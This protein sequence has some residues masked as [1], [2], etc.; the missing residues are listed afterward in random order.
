[1]PTTATHT[2]DPQTIHLRDATAADDAT[3]KRLIRQAHLDPTSLKW[4]HFMVAE[5]DGRIVGFGQVKSYPGCNEIGSLLTLPR[6]RGLG[7]ASRLMDALEARAGMPLYLLCLQKMVPFYEQHSYETIGW[8]Q[9][10]TF[11]KLKLLPA[12]L[13][14]LVGMRVHVMVKREKLT[15]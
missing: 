8:W 15:V 4:E 6:Y 1:M 10:P 5:H 7:I 12:Y 14:R 13:M 9:A 3:I 2:I 11:L